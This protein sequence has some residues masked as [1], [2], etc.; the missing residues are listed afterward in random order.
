MKTIF[1]V[2]HAKSSWEYQVKDIDRPLKERGINDAH[3][4]SNALK[5]NQIKI[6]YAFSSPANRALHTCT[7]FLRNLNFDLSRLSVSHDL[8]DFSGEGVLNYLKQI[9][10]T[11]Q[12]ILL[13]GHN[14]ALTTLVNTLGDRY[15]ENVP[16]SGLVQIDF[17]AENWKKI[18]KGNTK[19]VIFPKELR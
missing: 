15:I 7:I 8:Y 19:Q 6:D 17:E 13:F 14:Y 1:F 2:R 9:G 3:L 5:T 12:T 11:N 4:V 18:T 16:T 10:N